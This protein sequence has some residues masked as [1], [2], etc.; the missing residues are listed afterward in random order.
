[1]LF[2]NTSVRVLNH[3]PVDN[4]R[5][6]IENLKASGSKYLMM[7]DRPRW[8]ADQPEEIHMPYIEQLQLNDIGDSIMLI[9]L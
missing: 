1:M 2:S 4:S 6:A 7:T 8:H 5:N 3:F 9:E